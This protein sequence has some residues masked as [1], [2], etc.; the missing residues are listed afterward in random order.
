MSPRRGRRGT[1]RGVLS[2]GH[3]ASPGLGIKRRRCSEPRPS[4]PV[5]PVGDSLPSPSLRAFDDRLGPDGRGQAPPP[6]PLEACPARPSPNRS[7]PASVC[8]RQDQLLALGPVDQRAMVPTGGWRP[9]NI[10]PKR[11]A[12]PRISALAHLAVGQQRQKDR[13]RS[14]CRCGWICSGA[15]A[16]ARDRR[17]RHGSGP[18]RLARVA[19][20]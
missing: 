18:P 14:R 5:D 4:R 16:R 8:Q 10:A 17:A 9:A 1:R 19:L 13:R 6:P 15:A 7:R 11:M 12:R 3:A 20:S 2:T